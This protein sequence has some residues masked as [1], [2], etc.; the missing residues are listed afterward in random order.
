MPHLIRLRGPWQIDGASAES[1]RVRLPDDWSAILEA[2]AG[3]SRLALHRV[4]HCPTG[5]TASSRVDLRVGLAGEAE[6]FLN[7]RQLVPAQRPGVESPASCG[8]VFDLRGLLEPT[9]VLR[10]EMVID[11]ARQIGQSVWDVFLELDD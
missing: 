6:V 11:G 7:D 2:A 5:L 8:R 4:F 10:L 9:N 3:G 1:R